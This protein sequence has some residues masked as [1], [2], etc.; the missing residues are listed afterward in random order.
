[1]TETAVRRSTAGRSTRPARR[2]ID[3]ASVLTLILVL[4]I[5]V[6]SRLVISGLGGVGQPALVLA[7]AALVWWTFHQTQRPVR[8][9]VDAHP[10]R[11][12]LL[13]VVVAFSVSYVVAMTRPIAGDESSTANIGMVTLLAWSG[14]ALLAHD[15]IPTT[16]RLK[17][18]LDRMVIAGTALGLLAV[19]Q[20]LTHQDL[21]RDVVIPGLSLNRSTGDLLD[22]SGFARPSGTA[23]HPIELGAVLTMLLPVAITRAR[24]VRGG[25][26]FLA[27][28]CPGVI[29]LAALLSGSRSALLCALVAL[30]VLAAVWTNVERVVGLVGVLVVL[31]GVAVAI[32]S[33][34]GSLTKLFLRAGSDASVASR[35]DSYPLVGELVSRDPLFGRGFRTLM[36]SYRI[37]DNEYLGLLVEV[38]VVGLLSVV[39][40]VVTAGC[41]AVRARRLSRDPEVREYAQ[42]LLA[43]IAAAAVG[44]ATFDGLTFPMASA[45]FFLVLGLAG[46]TWR[47]VRRDERRR[48]LDAVRRGR[49]PAVPR[50]ARPPAS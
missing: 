26:S 46:G 9:S 48:A 7:L 17:R 34:L 15:G 14:I 28:L 30:L 23:L 10:V 20:F 27:W 24:L 3:G 29:G 11:L 37:L 44:L 42:A 47:L 18:L 8:A 36:P 33:L 40:L 38:G 49:G 50:V 43:S 21:V 45:L 2:R 39:L 5:G 12:A 13:S 32:P 22:R 19:A 35:T 6:Q 4:V 1:V 41:C 25:A 31:A 16:F